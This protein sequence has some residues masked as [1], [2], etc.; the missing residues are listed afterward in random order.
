M[1]LYW[2]HEKREDSLS[3]WHE[4]QASIKQLSIRTRIWDGEVAKGNNGSGFYRALRN[5]LGA[6]CIEWPVS[7]KAEIQSI[8]QLTIVK[9]VQKHERDEMAS[10]FDHRPG[11]NLPQ[12]SNPFANFI[13]YAA[14]P[15]SRNSGGPESLECYAFLARPVAIWWSPFLRN[16]CSYKWPLQGEN[17]HH[18]WW[19]TCLNGCTVHGGGGCRHCTQQMDSLWLSPAEGLSTTDLLKCNWPLVSF[20][21][22]TVHMREESICSAPKRLAF[23]MGNDK[24]NFQS[25]N[26]GNHKWK[27]FHEID[28]WQ[29]WPS[30]M[31]NG[32]CS[33]FRGQFGS[34]HDKCT[35]VWNCQFFP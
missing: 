3:N 31:D 14:M 9:S 22:M 12:I 15:C 6:R 27:S 19:H 8:N 26:S 4:I 18:Q 7:S 5:H 35:N 13:G 21:Y 16:I 32:H 2:L 29:I 24:W 10:P 34:H 23:Q 25:V 28:I 11:N 20:A 30:A 1:G 17:V 33:L